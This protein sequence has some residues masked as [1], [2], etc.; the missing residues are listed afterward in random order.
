MSDGCFQDRACAGVNIEKDLLDPKGSNPIDKQN[1][2]AVLGSER[3]HLG[4]HDAKEE[5]AGLDLPFL[6]RT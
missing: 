2:I 4:L 3:L 6:I 5:E 1:L